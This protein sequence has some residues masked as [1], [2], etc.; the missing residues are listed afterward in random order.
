MGLSYL[1]FKIFY[2]FKSKTGFL[3]ITF[4][5]HPKFQ[6]YISLE[7]W[8]QNM[9][10]FF[11]YGKKINGL[12]KDENPVLLDN[13]LSI[14]KG[15]LTFFNKLK[16]DLGEEYDWL[17]NPSTG[18][19]YDIGKHWSEIED[20]SKEAGDIK[21]V[22]EKARFSYLYDIIRYNYHYEEDQSEF[23]FN[24]IENFID[25]NPINK[26]PNYKCSQEISLRTLNWVFAL[27]YY[28]DS[29]FLT[30][31]LFAKI[32]YVVYWQIHHVYQNIHFS[33]IAV[34][35][36]HATMETMMLY[37]S[38][39]LFPFFPNV[40]KWSRKGKKWFEQEIAYQV[41]EDG[42]Y[43]Q[44]SMNYHRVLVQQLTWGIRLS[45]LNGDLLSK[46]VY[47]RAK[48]SLNFLDTC[49]DPV[50][51]KLPNYGSN[52]GALFF[53]L[54][55]SDYRNYKSQLDDLRAVL[56]NYAY[57]DY[58]SVFWYG[59]NPQKIEYEQPKP[60]ST[61]EKGGYYIIQEEGIKTFM[62]C[63]TYKDRPSQSDNL[64]LD[65]WINGENLLRD[66]GT[67]KYN[68]HQ[69]LLNYFG[70]CSAHNTVGIEDY[71]QMLR[72]SRFIW[73]Y[74]VKKA[75]AS[76][77]RESGYF[78]FEGKINAFR[79]V[80]SNIEHIRKIK[81]EQGQNKWEITDIVK[82]KK[83]NVI[84]QYWHLHP[85]YIDAIKIIT[86]DEEGI[87]IQPLIEERWYSSYY[88][89]K[90]ASIRITFATQTNI[91]NTEIKIDT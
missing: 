25:N 61:F 37:L 46:I 51:G 24:Q 28:K 55:D 13:Y 20:L 70:G 1:F 80:G 4:P 31:T 15:A 74:W 3:K 17:T 91:F 79:H 66:S 18:Y 84:Y 50:S 86:K 71:D 62:R 88:G 29:R 82:N 81:K 42:T 11:F 6:K 78:M 63:G 21:Y 56:Y 7:E 73:Y 53:K 57:F 60:V 64:H 9:P 12:K 58:E 23:V 59:L 44:F 39:K 2:V 34:R 87:E 16:L 49:M 19:K 52:D 26:G 33:R 35:N 48:R 36:N 83:D 76:L 43:L 8:K 27:Y 5:T 67:Y 30:E 41:Y 72:G 40:K 47:D 68:T 65:L 89:I 77:K 32:M 69:D 10:P 45:E 85:D 90:E 75:K 38:G 54:T 22:W 14:K